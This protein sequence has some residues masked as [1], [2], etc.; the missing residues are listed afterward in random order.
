M[1]TASRPYRARK[2]PE[3]P[4]HLLTLGQ[5]ADFLGVSLRFVELEIQRGKLRKTLLS[6]R[7]ARVSRDELERYVAA[8]TV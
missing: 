5:A 6:A 2:Q 8:S 1:S 4:Q 3:V 7:L